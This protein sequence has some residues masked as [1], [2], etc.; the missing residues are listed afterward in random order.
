MKMFIMQ[1]SHHLE[2]FIALNAYIRKEELSQV[3][4]LNFYLRCIEKNSKLKQIKHKEKNVT[5]KTKTQQKF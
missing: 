4:Y 2:K 3:N 1:F 5:S